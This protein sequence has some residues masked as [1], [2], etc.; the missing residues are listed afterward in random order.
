MMPMPDLQVVLRRINELRERGLVEQYAIGGAWA[1]I[2]F[3]EPILTE[4]LDVFCHLPSQNLHSILIE[5]LQRI[6]TLLETTT[7]PIEMERLSSILGKHV[8]AKARLGERTLLDRW[9]KLKE[10][11][12]AGK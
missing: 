11:R 9:T 6:E 7:R 3:S 2:Y 1:A 10:A 4:D 8:P 12:D 5:D